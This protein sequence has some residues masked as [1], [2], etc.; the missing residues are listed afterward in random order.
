MMAYGAENIV[1]VVI[2]PIFLFA[3]F[4]GQYLEIGTFAAIIVIIGL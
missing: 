2:W 3:I 1:G 4:D